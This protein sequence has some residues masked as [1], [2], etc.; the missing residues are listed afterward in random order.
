MSEKRFPSLC[1]GD[2][3]LS[4]LEERFPSS[5]EYEG[6]LRLP[7]L[8]ERFPLSLDED[9]RLLLGDEYFRWRS[10]WSLCDRV[11][12]ERVLLFLD[13]DL[14]FLLLEERR[15]LVREGWSLLKLATKRRLFGCVF[16]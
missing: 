9:L 11:S 4:C 2:L 10:D 7:C 5:L 14:L 16:W 15:V 6:D 3:R 12:E 1:E 13:G 8:E